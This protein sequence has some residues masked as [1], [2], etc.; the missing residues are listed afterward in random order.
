MNKEKI[1]LGIKYSVTLSDD[2]PVKGKDVKEMLRFTRRTGW[3]LGALVGAFAII[4]ELLLVKS[5]TEYTPE[6]TPKT[7]VINSPLPTF[8]GPYRF[9]FANF[10]S[11]NEIRNL[12]IIGENGQREPYGVYSDGDWNLRH[13]DTGALIYST[14]KV[15]TTQMPRVVRQSR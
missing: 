4:G 13:D 8:K 5:L 15:D 2:E 1:R 14:A 3:T 10:G 11:N 12:D 7:F 6:Q 9:E